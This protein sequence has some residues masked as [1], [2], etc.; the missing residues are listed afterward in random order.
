MLAGPS[1]GMNWNLEIEDFVFQSRQNGKNIVKNLF[2]ITGLM[3]HVGACL[4]A[5]VTIVCLQFQ[6][7]PSR[8]NICEAARLLSCD[9]EDNPESMNGE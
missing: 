9:L 5:Y 8:R 1:S 2:Q 3:A 6:F 4:R 7:A